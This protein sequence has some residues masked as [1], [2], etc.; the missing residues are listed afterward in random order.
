M[1]GYYY[2]VVQVIVEMASMWPHCKYDLYVDLPEVAFAII[3][4]I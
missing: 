2:Y 4:P 1:S 3:M